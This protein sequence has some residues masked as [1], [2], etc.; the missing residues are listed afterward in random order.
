MPIREVLPTSCAIAALLPRT[1]REQGSVD[2]L[3][4]TEASR[5]NFRIPPLGGLAIVLGVIAVG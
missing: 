2:P 4:M 5:T 3:S 1:R